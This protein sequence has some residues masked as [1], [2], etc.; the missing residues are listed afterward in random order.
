MG[1][2]WR[3]SIIPV[4]SGGIFGELG[5]GGCGAKVTQRLK[6]AKVILLCKRSSSRNHLVI[7]ID[8]VILLNIIIMLFSIFTYC[9]S[10]RSLYF[11]KLWQK[12]FWYFCGAVLNFL[13]RFCGAGAGAGAVK[14][15]KLV[16][17]RS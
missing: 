4:I 12:S 15:L 7:Y 1:K 13:V 6:W 16:R 9:L 17:V 5:G 11:L 14:K 8:L 3:D 2:D 10:F